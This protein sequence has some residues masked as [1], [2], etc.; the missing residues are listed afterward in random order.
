MDIRE[1]VGSIEEMV[2][3]GKQRVALKPHSKPKMEAVVKIEEEEEED[4]EE[5][6]GEGDGG[7][8]RRVLSEEELWARLDE[9]E[10]QE[11]QEEEHHR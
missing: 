6:S 5:G 2:S 9:L 10:A 3:K 8:R 1:E 11:E 4:D 7:S